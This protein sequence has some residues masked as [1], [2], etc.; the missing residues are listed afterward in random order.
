MMFGTPWSTRIAF[1]VSAAGTGVG[2]ALSAALFTSGSICLLCLLV[3]AANLMLCVSLFVQVS[4]QLAP[5]DKRPLFSSS[6]TWALIALMIATTSGLVGAV[7]SHPALSQQAK[8]TSKLLADYRSAPV[9]DIPVDPADATLGRPDGRVRLVVFSSFQCHWCQVFAPSVHYLTEEYGDRLTIV[10]KNYPLGKTCNPGLASDMQP[11][12]CAAAWAA[13][14]AKRQN[15]FWRFH[16]GLFSDSLDD[17]DELLRAIARGAGVNME[18]WEKDR[19]SPDI[20]VKITNDVALGAR[21]GVVGTPTVFLNNRRVKNPSLPV[22][23]T[24]IKEE[25][26]KST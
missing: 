1:L 19:Q 5:E 3:H 23:E 9:F 13:E 2:L 25:I 11:R 18:Q 24:L 16:D 20:R 21:L 8:D 12:S 26:K 6:K 22:L 7:L 10:F 4:K 17:T 15:A 14:A